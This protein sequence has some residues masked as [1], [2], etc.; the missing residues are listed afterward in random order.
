MMTFLL[1]SA[2]GCV[3]AHSELSRPFAFL[4]RV[5]SIQIDLSKLEIGGKVRCQALRPRSPV[6]PEE[7]RPL[8]PHRRL[9]QALRLP[10]SR[11]LRLLRPPRH[12]RRYLCSRCRCPRGFRSAC[13]IRPSSC[14]RSWAACRKQHNR[15]APQPTRQLARP[16]AR[17]PATDARWWDIP[18]Q[19]RPQPRLR[20]QLQHCVRRNASTTCGY[21]SAWLRVSVDA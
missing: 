2:R 19:P 3:V 1:A 10:E 11:P 18:R 12:L 20:S 5:Q 15:C 17:P 9:R 13:R 7:L 8:P 4:S 6:C 14:L 21:L 16:P